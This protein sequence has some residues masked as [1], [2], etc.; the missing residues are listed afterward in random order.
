MSRVEVPEWGWKAGLNTGLPAWV[1][2][3]L[4]AIF[5]LI[6]FGASQQASAQDLEPRRWSHLPTGMNVAGGGYTYT[7]ANIYFNPIWNITNGTAQ[8][9]TLG[10]GVIHNFDLAGK[11][12]R[13][14]L[15]LPYS[16]G[17]WDGDVEGE[18]RQ[19]KRH[20][21]GDPRLRFSVN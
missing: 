21:A 16:S 13:F 17:R 20:G 2:K 9:N 4:I 6:G 1:V 11:S 10:L 14:S 19:I 15:L 5:L 3:S 7:D 18:F 8:I 12:A